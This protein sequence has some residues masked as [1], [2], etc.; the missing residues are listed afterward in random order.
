MIKWIVTLF[1]LTWFCARF[2][3]RRKMLLRIQKEKWTYHQPIHA[4]TQTFFFSY[5][6]HIEIKKHLFLFVCQKCRAKIS[7]KMMIYTYICIHTCI[8]FSLFVFHKCRHVFFP[9]LASNVCHRDSLETHSTSISIERGW[10]FRSNLFHIK[11]FFF[12]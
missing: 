2:P 12:P 11:W 3:L 4:L 9:F 7:K 10:L 5:G 1:K 6:F 8:L